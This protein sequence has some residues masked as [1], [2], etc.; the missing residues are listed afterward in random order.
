MSNQIIRQPIVLET[1]QA[2]HADLSTNAGFMSIVGVPSMYYPNGSSVGI[3]PSLVETA[4]VVTVTP[5]GADSTNY[6]LNIIQYNKTSQRFVTYPVTFKSN[7]SG[8]TATTV[9]TA[10]KAYIN[11]LVSASNGL[12][13]VASGTSTLVITGGTGDPLFTVQGITSSVSVATTMPTYAP[14]ATP[15]TA[16]AGTTTVTVTTASAH[17][18][19]V[20]QSVNITTATGFTFTRNGVATV[21]AITNVRVAT[22]PTSATFT[23]YETTGSGTNTGTIVVTGVAQEAVGTYALV[24]ADIANF[25]T[26][27]GASG[28]LPVSG[29]TYAT[30]I[31]NGYSV[32]SGFMSEDSR[33][34]YQQTVYMQDTATTALPTNFNALKVAIQNELNGLNAA[35]S[36]ADAELIAAQ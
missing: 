14:H 1:F 28:T 8:T 15:G 22:V 34:G 23:L 27:T 7:S 31:F 6:E 33:Q 18:L 32:P 9:V 36:A 19:S 13:V 3:L 35:G 26:E 20:G 5:S 10:L 2:T 12:N 24:N 25:N 30:F 17:G 16:L 21:A 11:A 29:H 4:N